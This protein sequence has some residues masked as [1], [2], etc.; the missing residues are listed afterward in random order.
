LDSVPPDSFVDACEV[1]QHAAVRPGVVGALLLIPIGVTAVGI[2]L[3]L[4]RP[5]VPIK[6]GAGPVIFP[7]KMISPTVGWAIVGTSE[8][9]RTTDGGTSWTDVSPPHLPDRVVDADLNYFV[10]GTRALI[11]QLGGGK[12]GNPVF[13]WVTFRTVDGGR[14]WQEG[15]SVTG[16]SNAL[17][18]RVFFIDADTGWLVFSDTS[19]N[20]QLPILYGT[21]DG[22]LHWNLV[23]SK[24]GAGASL[25]T[26]MPCDANV[27]FSSAAT[28]WMLL[29]LC[30]Q[31]PSQNGATVPDR[32]YVR[33]ILLL[34]HDGGRTWQVQSLPIDP[35]PGS[36]FD[37]PVFFDQLHGII[38]IHGPEPTLLA[39]SD[40]GGTWND[41]SLPGESQ[42]E[43]EFIDP[44]HGWALAGPSSMF[45]KTKDNSQRIISLPLYHTDNGG[46]SWTPVRTNLVVESP[47]GVVFSNVHFV[48]QATGFL[49]LPTLALGPSQFLKTTD[50]GT[51][52]KVIRV[53]KKGLGWTN[54]SP[55]C[56]S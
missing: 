20:P 19:P 29:A 56:P 28:G 7:T 54:P 51:T 32:S 35:P 8:L 31:S 1:T 10:D 23:T 45:V 33:D 11:T 34:T 47:I 3:A 5:T 18:P 21:R 52:W 4:H 22:G 41:R 46:S 36:S 37:I 24:A 44:N 26:A 43:V 17:S 39:T 53:C 40:G 49:T 30:D 9:W 2:L 25:G 16:S 14:T 27:M 48:D 50:G 13:C 12:P 42:L 15:T 38:A 6:P 55:A